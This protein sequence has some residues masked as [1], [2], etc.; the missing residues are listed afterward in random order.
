[1]GLILGVNCY[2][3]NSSICLLDE[4]GKIIFFSEE[5]RFNRIKNFTGF[6][7]LAFKYIENKYC[8]PSQI[9]FITINSNP[10][11]NIF[12]KMFFSLKN[13]SLDFLNS[14]LNDYKKKI[15]FNQ[16]KI[17]NKIYIDHHLSHIASSFYL[18]NFE[19]SVALSIDGFGDFS[20][21]SLAVINSN[22]IKI[23]QK[24]FFPHSLGIFYHAMTQFIGFNNYGDEYKVM[25]M[26]AYGN[27]QTYYEK[28]KNLIFY[29]EDFFYRINKKYFN[30]YKKNIF[31]P[32]S[33]GIPI[34]KSIFN[35][36]IKDLI[37]MPRQEN[38]LLT[39]KF[40]DLAAS[41]Q[42]I[43]EEIFFKILNKI[44]K[45]N[46]GQNLSLSGGCAMNSLANGKI[47]LSTPFKNVF[48]PA[49]PGDSGGAIGAALYFFYKKNK[50]KYK[51]D[52]S[53]PYLGSHYTNYEIKEIINK[54][55]IIF[56]SKNINS[57]FVSTE[58]INS[59]A[60]EKISQGS[61]IAIFRGK[62][63]NG[64]RA[65]G[66]RSL[67]GDPRQ[68]KIAKKMNLIIKKREEFRPFA[69]SILEEFA[70]QWYENCTTSPYMSHV[71][72]VI[73]NQEKIIPAVTHVDGT[74]RI[75]TVNKTVNCDYYDLIKKFYHITSVPMILNTSFN[76]NEPI[77]E[78]PHN[79]IE[80]FI[81]NPIDY[82]V[83]ENY[84]LEKK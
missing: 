64:P 49:T 52:N 43:Y 84:L 81:N 63:E 70:D 38:D 46:P 12:K 22:N 77:I 69:P 78:N 25:G 16:F 37:G 71:F 41:T 80:F 10:F 28:L 11:K 83:L 5:E 42:K 7:S 53:N 15:F 30:F 20:S 26:S 29:D 58:K 72:K 6:P 74:G 75:Q 44:Y 76:D 24:V 19:E 31:Y 54:F 18:S 60:A 61:I 23:K 1:M 32:T 17:K 67:V 40:F 82:L 73:K 62:M 9:K 79:A 50:I 51:I 68:E 55:D 8:N 2:H 27:P 36:N 21:L 13:F 59:I 45:N 66:N 39:Q 65:L 47:I 35:K 57:I 4:S 33:Q 34:Y 56:Q 14:R 48:I 3:P